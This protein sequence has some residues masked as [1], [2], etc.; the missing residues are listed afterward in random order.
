MVEDRADGFDYQ[1]LRHICNGAYMANG[2]YER[3]SAI[4][5]IEREQADFIAF[6]KLFIA[7]PDLPKR[8]RLNAGFNPAR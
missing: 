4:D 3:D 7:N 8:L 1:K 5:A 2:G 6:G